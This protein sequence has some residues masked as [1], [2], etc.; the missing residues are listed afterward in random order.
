LLYELNQKLIPAQTSQVLLEPE[1]ISGSVH[2]TTF[3][4]PMFRAIPRLLPALIFMGARA[5]PFQTPRLSQ[6]MP[7]SESLLGMG[8]ITIVYWT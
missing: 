8:R 5:M 6:S 1:S 7:R 2:T 4:I 3:P